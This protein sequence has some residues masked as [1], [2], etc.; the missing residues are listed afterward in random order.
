LTQAG[1]QVQPQPT[2][3]AQHTKPTMNI[4]TSRFVSASRPH[5]TEHFDVLIVG[6]GISGVA[7]PIT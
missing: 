7:A 2:L 3:I 4:A 1:K 6:A 5:A